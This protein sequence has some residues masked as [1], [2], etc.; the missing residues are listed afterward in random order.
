MHWLC[1]KCDN[2]FRGHWVPEP[3]AGTAIVHQPEFAAS[4]EPNW[5]AVVSNEIGEDIVESRSCGDEEEMSDEY[6]AED[7]YEKP[8]WAQ[9]L[10]GEG[11]DGQANQYV[12]PLHHSIPDLEMSAAQGCQLCNMIQD[13]FPTSYTGHETSNQEIWH[14]FLEKSPRLIGVICVRPYDSQPLDRGVCLEISYFVDA[15]S[16]SADAYFFSAE[17]DLLPAA[18]KFIPF[19][20]QIDIGTDEETSL[21]VESENDLSCPI[22]ER[23]ASEISNWVRTCRETHGECWKDTTVSP[24]RDESTVKLPARVIDIYDGTSSPP[25][26]RV[27]DTSTSTFQTPYM[28]LSHCWG[29]GLH[30]SLLQSNASV[31]YNEIPWSRMPRTF[32]EAITFTHQLGVKFLWIDALCI[33][34]DSEADWLDQALSMA[35]IY[36]NS[37]LN[38]AST[39]SENGDGGLF[40]ARNP[41]LANGCLIR[42]SWRG[43]PPGEFVIF[44]DTAWRRRIEEGVLNRRAWVLQER[45]LAQRTVHFAYDQISWECAC[46]R[47][48]ESYPT[49]MPE[50]R[51]DIKPDAVTAFQNIKSQT[52][53]ST[54]INNSWLVIVSRYSECDLTKEDDKLIALAGV[55]EMTQKALGCS[56][57]YYLAGLWKTSLVKDL[58][59]RLVSTGERYDTYQAPSWSWASVKGAVNFNPSG[60]R[61]VDHEALVIQLQDVVIKHADVSRPFGRVSSGYVEVAAPLYRIV[62]GSTDLTAGWGNPVLQSITINGHEFVDNQTLAESL[63]HRAIYHTLDRWVQTRSTYFCRFAT[64]A[65]PALDHNYSSDGLLLE[66]SPDLERGYLRRFGWVRLFHNESEEDFH[67]S[68]DGSEMLDVPAYLNLLPGGRYVFRII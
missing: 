58:L 15:A 55:A 3:A 63:D 2:I 35:S 40:I 65:Q 50:E 14:M 20:Q 6:S 30:F 47:A 25:R 24:S 51:V 12:S 34:Q 37:L 52:Q 11:R 10:P 45:L 26:V 4:I 18:D 13:Q 49:G 31:L 44:D 33:V 8:S 19:P 22:R 21:T 53:D 17:F 68:C 38:L 48:S 9:L 60:A 7:F 23:T 56:E 1:S 67:L 42:A 62:L 66:R 28:T 64:V 29:E 61:V 36:S 41:Y 54:Q 43:L 59:W 16:R 46:I 5:R 27:I 57:L 32:R 39:S